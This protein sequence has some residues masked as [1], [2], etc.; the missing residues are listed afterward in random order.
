MRQPQQKRSYGRSGRNRNEAE[1]QGKWGHDKFKEIHPMA[2]RLGPKA[3]AGI[4]RKVSKSGQI[5]LTSSHVS[6]TKLKKNGAMISI[7]NETAFN[8][9]LPI[10]FRGNSGVSTLEITGL[11][12]EATADDL[13]VCFIYVD[14]LQG[15]FCRMRGC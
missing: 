9:A 15:Y 6:N 1:I 7:L 10:S 4:V 14:E 13:Q 11:H 8:D 3:G 5:Q 2:D 12:P